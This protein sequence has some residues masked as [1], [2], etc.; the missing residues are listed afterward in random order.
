M[1]GIILAG[2]AGTR[3]YLENFTALDPRKK[4]SAPVIA[5]RADTIFHCAQTLLTPGK[6]TAVLNFANAYSPGGGVL[7]GAM[8][9]EECLCRSINLYEGLT[10]PY[11][12]QHYYQWN[13]K[14]TGDMGT[15]RLVYSPDVTVFMSDHIYPEKL[16][17]WFSVDVITCAAPYYNKYKKK[18]VSK[19]A[20]A[21]VF[22][23]RIR[24]ILESAIDNDV[25]Y[26]VL[27]A[28]GCGA[29]NN[30][31]QLVAEAFRKLLVDEGYG[32]C[33]EKVVFAIKTTGASRTNLD[34]FRAC[35]Q[36]GSGF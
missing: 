1:K 7:Q 23:R 19:E 22:I 2:G 26:L 28:F 9:Q 27:G 16:D 32:L 29:F 8:A 3:L 21:A 20:L 18:P 31:P 25:D 6:R 11:L 4:V 5:V 12:M 10:I 34:T 33:F 15:D 36:T 13:E 35:F 14:N 17:D 24:N 30:P